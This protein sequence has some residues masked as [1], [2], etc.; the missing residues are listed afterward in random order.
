MG[1]DPSGVAPSLIHGGPVLMSYTLTLQIPAWAAS[2]T[3]AAY[4][5]M[6]AALQ[7]QLE[8]AH[9]ET[10]GTPPSCVMA[11]GN[12]LV[13]RVLVDQGQ[14]Q[15]ER[16]LE[17]VDG[18]QR[19]VAFDE[20]TREFLA[21]LHAAR[22]YLRPVLFVSPIVQLRAKWSVNGDSADLLHACTGGRPQVRDD[23]LM[24]FHFLRANPAQPSNPNEV[25]MADVRVEPFV[26]DRRFVWIE[27]TVQE[28]L[29]AL[30]GLGVFFRGP[31]GEVRHDGDSDV[32]GIV[33]CARKAHDLL[34]SIPAF[35]GLEGA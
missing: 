4:G 33:A 23:W 12:G 21:A 5:E 30:P 19:I 3:S 27:A 17:T 31:E 25:S 6:Y 29:V 34:D 26:R 15:C 7:S 16:N 14:F 20:I 1:S 28:P 11:R 2:P 10:P 8:L 24:G 9:L 35:L 22:R 18:A 32:S 13:I